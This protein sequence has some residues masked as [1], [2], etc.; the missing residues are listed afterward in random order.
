MFLILQYPLTDLRSIIPNNRRL[1]KPQWPTPDDNTSLRHFGVV[2]PR[3]AGGVDDW[4]GEQIFCLSRRAI[5][6]EQL[7]QQKLSF[8]GNWLEFKGAFRRFFSNGRFM[9]KF[10]LALTNPA[11]VFANEYAEG[12]GPVKPLAG[13]FEAAIRSFLE[14]KVFFQ[15][16]KTV[17][18][19]ARLYE[20][21][22]SLA[23]LYLTGSTKKRHLSQTQPWWIKAGKPL[24]VIV[25]ENTGNLELPPHAKKQQ[26]FAQHGVTLYSLLYPVQKNKWIKCWLIGVDLRHDSSSSREFIRQLRINLFRINAEKEALRHVLNEISSGNHPIEEEETRQSLADYLEE[27]TSKLL[28]KVR[29]GIDQAN[30]LEHALYNEDAATPGELETLLAQLAPLKNKFIQ[31]NL[32]KLGNTYNLIGNFG[33]VNI[34][35]QIETKTGASV[36]VDTNVNVKDGGHVDQ[37]STTEK[38]DIITTKK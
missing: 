21:G 33:Q 31:K 4:P 14:L 37:L 36:K 23:K 18:D 38:G 20:A 34:S 10:E 25:F 1:R 11:D 7:T 8:E 12:E 35:T 6:I 26:E 27:A 32:E 3:L 24:L 29:H 15:I 5:R 30:I 16:S 2:T 13:L 9:G 19:Q 17:K 28:R 22:P